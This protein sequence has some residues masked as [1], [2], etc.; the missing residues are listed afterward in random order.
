MPTEHTRTCRRPWHRMANKCEHHRFSACRQTRGVAVRP[1]TSRG[2]TFIR[3]PRLSAVDRTPTSKT[4][5]GPDRATNHRLEPRTYPMARKA[6]DDAHTLHDRGRPADPL[7][8]SA[9]PTGDARTASTTSSRA[10]LCCLFGLPTSIDHVRSHGRSSAARRGSRP[11]RGPV[12]TSPLRR[13]R[14]P[15]PESMRPR[16]AERGRT[17]RTPPSIPRPSIPGRTHLATGTGTECT[18]EGR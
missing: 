11:C 10:G 18:G 2:A 8:P 15:R 6:P 17:R 5:G 7:P 14:G 3:P 12:R 4:P 13:S 9:H 16:P 1:D